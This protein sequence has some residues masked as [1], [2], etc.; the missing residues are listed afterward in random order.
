MFLRSLKKKFGNKI[1]KTVAKHWPRFKSYFTQVPHMNDLGNLV[2]S[3]YHS[4]I[5]NESL[6]FIYN[7]KVKFEKLIYSFFI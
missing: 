4:N 7:L 6:K 5:L 1:G 2:L 3:K